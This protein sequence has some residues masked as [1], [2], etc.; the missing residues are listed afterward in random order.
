VTSIRGILAT[1]IIRPVNDAVEF[2]Y[3]TGKPDMSMERRRNPR[4]NEPLSVTVRGSD[5]RGESYQFEAVTQDICARGLRCY[6]PRM[7]AVGEKVFLHVRFALAGSHP[8]QAP[9]VS[10]QAV[11]LRVE[12]RLDG[13]CIFAASFIRCHFI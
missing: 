8:S 5:G 13:S 10:A 6:A 7:M 9:N 12:E 2:V 1:E 3:G 11:V 4:V